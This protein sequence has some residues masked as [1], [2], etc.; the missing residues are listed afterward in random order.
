MGGGSSRIKAIVAMLRDDDE[1]QHLTGL[2][3]LCEYISIST[4]DSMMTFPVDQ[5]VPQL[6][7]LLGHEHNPDVML[8]AARALT[9]LADVYPPSAMSI[10][11]HGAV[12]AFCARLLTI[13]YIDLAEQSLQ[14]LEKLSH[15]HPGPLLRAGALVAVL[16]YIDFFQTGV[17]RVAA[18]TAANICRGITIEHVDA[19]ITAA[20][21]LITLLRYSDAKIVDSACLALTRI[22]EVFSKSTEHM[23]TLCSFGLITSIVEMVAVS[24]NGS[25]SSQL[26]SSTFYGLIKLLATCASGSHIVAESLLQAGVSGTMRTLLAT[27]PLLAITGASPGNA[28]RSAD[29]LQALVALTGELLPPVPDASTTFLGEPRPWTS[30]LG[31]TSTASGTTNDSSSLDVYI[32]E[33]PD[34]AGRVSS[35]LFSVM[36]RVYTSSVTPQV[37]RHSLGALTKMLYHAPATTLKS[38]LADLPI[39]SLVAS[40]LKSSDPA[41]VA[42]GMQMAEIL[43]M[44]LPDVFSK[45]FLKEGVVHAM[46]DLAQSGAATIPPAEVRP[47]CTGTAA[48]VGD[49][50]RTRTRMATRGQQ[51]QEQGEGKNPTLPPAPFSSEVR[52]PAG[53]VLRSA[54]STHA[55]RFCEKYFTDDRGNTLGT[56]SVPLNLLKFKKQ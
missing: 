38:L 6:V 24:D 18:A 36:L 21:I 16:S 37:K 50:I 12:P 49:E 23:Q 33:H 39:S 31:S 27:S 55:R 7:T 19:A 54:L 17:Q 9:F 11:R 20:P 35:D 30:E 47:D 22:A 41:V 2:N 53:S 56:F 25:I 5:V 34:A 52:T 46:E 43:M 10:I 3:E 44:K 13:E 45:F 8:L 1:M 26:T 28:L 4:E 48:L 40:L 32:R 42:Q 29:Q 14:A 15:D 51:L